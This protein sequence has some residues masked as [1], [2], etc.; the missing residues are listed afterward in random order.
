MAISLRHPIYPP[1]IA[2]SRECAPM[3]GMGPS[4]HHKERDELLEVLKACGG[5]RSEAARRL[6]V[7]RVTIWKRMKKYSIEPSEIS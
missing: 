2:K 4:N 5:N 7:S 6:G 1:R 3:T